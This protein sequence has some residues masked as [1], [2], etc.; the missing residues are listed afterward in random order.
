MAP[1]LSVNVDTLN[2]SVPRLQNVEVSVLYGSL[3]DLDLRAL[4]SSSID[5]SIPCR[6]AQLPTFQPIVLFNSLD[7]RNSSLFVGR[8]QESLAL[9]QAL[10]NSK[11]VHIYG[12]G[13]IGKASFLRHFLT[14]QADLLNAIFPG[15][16][17]SPTIFDECDIEDIAQIIFSAFFRSPFYYKPSLSEIERHFCGKRF[18]VIYDQRARPLSQADVRQLSQI[19]PSG[20][21]I[22]VSEEQVDGLGDV[23]IYLGGLLPSESRLLAQDF[24]GFSLGHAEQMFLDKIC[25]ILQGNPSLI[26]HSLCPVRHQVSTLLQQYH[27]LTQQ[28]A[29]PGHPS[30][31]PDQL[32][33]KEGQEILSVLTIFKNYGLTKHQ[34]KEILAQP[35]LNPILAD[36]KQAAWINDV[37]FLP[38]SLSTF[39]PSQGGDRIK[40]GYHILQALNDQTSLNHSRSI[41]NYF[42]GLNWS[43]I[44]QD[45]NLSTS[46]ISPLVMLFRQAVHESDPVAILTLGDLLAFAC[47]RLGLWGIRENVFLSMLEVCRDTPLSIQILLNLGLQKLCVSSHDQSL[48]YLQ[49]AQLLC[50]MSFG[51][52]YASVI[53][54]Y[55]HVVEADQQQHRL[56]PQR[57]TEIITLQVIDEDEKGVMYDSPLEAMPRTGVPITSLASDQGAGQSLDILYRSVRACLQSIRLP[58]LRHNQYGTLGLSLGMV[59]YLVFLL[60]NGNW[61]SPYPI[62]SQDPQINNRDSRPQPSDDSRLMT[63]GAAANQSVSN[64]QPRIQSD[65]ESASGSSLKT[66]GPAETVTTQPV[67]AIHR[68]SQWHAKAITTPQSS[69]RNPVVPAQNAETET[70]F[71]SPRAIE[72]QTNPTNQT[73]RPRP[74]VSQEGV[75]AS[76]P[77]TPSSDPQT[78][79]ISSPPLN[80]VGADLPRPNAHLSEAANDQASTLSAGMCSTLERE[81]ALAEQSGTRDPNFYRVLLAESGC[82]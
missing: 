6:P 75:L 1:S 62:S 17:V 22:Y 49:K 21:F 72:R 41:Y 79:T 57:A 32:C 3:D 68:E 15:G 51:Q 45:K 36:L 43:L 58:P 25:D 33:Q 47:L 54:H 60:S 78:I 42:L 30:N 69:S 18:L 44:I 81:L 65:G 13:G 38:N 24:L 52:S 10:V 55:I 23:S 77:S 27:R 64:R 66:Q 67:Q 26:L 39:D 31:Y 16:V 8:K 46:D 37:S 80:P 14:H 40:L 48:H 82:R 29:N 2:I 4:G 71:P 34:V 76:L 50:D 20:L 56:T 12:A 5:L 19:F 74:E 59:V 9:A 53:H 35:A 73:S 70:T 28:V 7:Q 11:N 61:L 63:S